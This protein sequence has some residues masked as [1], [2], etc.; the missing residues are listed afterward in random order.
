M[1]QIWIVPFAL[2]S[3]HL[4]R[5][6]P[7]AISVISMRNMIDFPSAMNKAQIFIP[8]LGLFD[9]PAFSFVYMYMCVASSCSESYYL[10]DFEGYKSH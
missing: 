5:C 9:W 2:S 3:V 7:P 4:L 1:P 10:S 8:F 6:E